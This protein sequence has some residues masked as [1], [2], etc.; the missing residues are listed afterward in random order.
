MF[1][2]SGTTGRPKGV[3]SVEPGA[4]LDAM[5]VQGPGFCAVFGIPADGV[6]LLCGPWYHSAQFAWSMLPFNAGSTV[7]LQRRFDPTRVLRAIDEHGVTNVHL[8]PTQFV[9][10]LALPAD[11]HTSLS[12]DSLRSCGTAPRRAAPT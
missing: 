10:L 4:P 5:K 6:T 2:T 8:V 12:T 7:V 3:R 9:R 1:Y 11:V